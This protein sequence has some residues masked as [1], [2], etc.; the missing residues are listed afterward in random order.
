MDEADELLIDVLNQACGDGEGGIDNACTKAY[1][2][3]CTY[4]TKKGLL[5]EVN[6]R[7][8]NIIETTG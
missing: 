3:A 4:L 1:E 6:S 2:D 5:Q 7:I 8:Y